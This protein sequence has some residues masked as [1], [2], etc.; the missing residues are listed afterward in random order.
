MGCEAEARTWERELL[1]PKGLR[2]FDLAKMHFKDHG[3]HCRV[4]R[5]S[6]LIVV[7]PS[8]WKCFW[9][10]RETCVMFEIDRSSEQDGQIWV[11]TYEPPSP[12]YPTDRETHSVTDKRY[13]HFHVNVPS[14]GELPRRTGPAHLCKITDPDCLDQMLRVASQFYGAIERRKFDRWH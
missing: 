11:S 3:Y 4:H 7:F 12:P 1:S 6:Y 2:L 5:D 13:D 10:N 8:W 9:S 14:R